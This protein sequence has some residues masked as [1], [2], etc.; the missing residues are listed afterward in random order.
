MGAISLRALSAQNPA[1]QDLVSSAL[2]GDDY[3]T[4]QKRA[5]ANETA[6]VAGALQAVALDVLRTQ[7]PGIVFRSLASQQDGLTAGTATFTWDEIDWRGMAKVISNYADDL[8]DV[9]EMVTSNQGLIRSL[10]VSFQYSKQDLRS[11]AEARRLGRQNIVLDAEKMSIA[12]EAMERL[13]DKIAAVGDVRAK[14]PGIFKNLNVTLLSASAPASGT[15]RRWNGPDKTGQEIVNDLSALMTQVRTQ[16]LGIHEVN[17]VV[18]PIEAEIAWR[19]KY[20]LYPNAAPVTAQQ[21][22][23]RRFPNVRIVGWNRAALADAAGTGPRVLAYQNDPTVLRVVEPLD[24]EA[25]SPQVVN[26]S[27]KVPCEARFGGIFFKRPLAAA[28]MDFV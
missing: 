25:S 16:S 1:M 12:R 15:N 5:D 28:Y 3:G 2:S 24:F 13:K 9:S 21:E 14:L 7:Y 26:L 11:V 27:F 18:M 20:I 6:I 17:T 23:A 10:G 8:P 19:T 22:F 4:P